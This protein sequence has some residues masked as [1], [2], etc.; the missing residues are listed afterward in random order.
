MMLA[1]PYRMRP[2]HILSNCERRLKFLSLIQSAVLLF[3]IIGFVWVMYGSHSAE[4]ERVT[5]ANYFIGFACGWLV[6]SRY[7]TWKY[8]D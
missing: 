7:Y 8:F 5:M 3:V 1:H 2:R 6:A 4:R